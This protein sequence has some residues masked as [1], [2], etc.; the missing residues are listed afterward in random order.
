M[1]FRMLDTAG[2]R[3]NGCSSALQG[4]GAVGCNHALIDMVRLRRFHN[5]L[6]AE[7]RTAG[8]RFN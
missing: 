6:D 7:E 1:G 2:T 8:N 3:C 4:D 5:G